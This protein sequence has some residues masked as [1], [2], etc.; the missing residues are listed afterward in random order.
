LHSAHKQKTRRFVVGGFSIL[1]CSDLAL[2]GLR[3]HADGVMM[4]AVVAMSEVSHFAY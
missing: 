2:P 3:R 1:D 4:M